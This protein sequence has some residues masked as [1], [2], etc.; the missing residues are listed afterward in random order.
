MVRM[1][2]YARYHVLLARLVSAAMALTVERRR[3]L[4]MKWRFWSTV[5][6]PELFKEAEAAAQKEIEECN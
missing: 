1:K 3:P 4:F 2:T 5:K 6:R